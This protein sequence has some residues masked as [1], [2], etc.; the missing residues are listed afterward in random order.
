MLSKVLPAIWLDAIHEKDKC[1]ELNLHVYLYIYIY[2]KGHGHV[3]L[4]ETILLFFPSNSLKCSHF[5]C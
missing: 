2:R 1:I 5:L 3:Q 4:C